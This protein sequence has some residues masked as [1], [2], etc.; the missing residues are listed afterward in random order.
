MGGHYTSSFSYYGSFPLKHFFDCFSGWSIDASM[1]YT[2]GS[3]VSGYGPHHHLVGPD[4]AAVVVK[5][6]WGIQPLMH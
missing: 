4:A 6:A 3:I 1:L 2:A 5:I